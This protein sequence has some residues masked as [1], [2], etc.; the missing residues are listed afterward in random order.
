M[1]GVPLGFL[2]WAAGFLVVW[3]GLVSVGG[4]WGTVAQHWPIAA[5]MA[6]GSYFAGSTPMGGG[7]VGF[8]VLVLLFDMPASL[9]RNFG[10]AVQSVGMVSASI[11]ILLRRQPIDWH[12]LRPA[13]LGVLVGTPAGATWLAPVMPDLTVKLLFA[14]IWASFGIMHLVKLRSLVAASGRADSWPGVDRP[15]G[16]AV[17]FAGGLVA[18][19][20][21]VGCDMMIYAVLVL[22]YRADL[23]I[24]IP[25]SV[26][27]MAFASVVGI[28]SNLLL[29]RVSAAHAID[30]EVYA[31]WLAAAPV[32]LVGA[33]LGAI[34][35]QRLPR[36]P[37]LTIVSLLCI[38]QFAWTLLHEQ[39][40]GWT[41][42]ATVAG[43]LA[44][45]AAFHWMYRCGERGGSRA[46]PPA[47]QVIPASVRCDS[48]S[49]RAE[50]GA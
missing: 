25:T 23:R 28:L 8:P 50:R 38:G 14:V 20:T 36:G 17:G 45:N 46:A 26:I 34:I 48:A 31:N 6:A 5:A 10:L 41:L 33:P 27:L 11:Y 22:M 4:H 12:L 42:L 49:A 29:A 24:A 9:G 35:V 13:L 39:V 7:T 21:G 18:S 2:A 1:F 40:T 47:G 32:V 30:P 44:M 19:L 43:L 16:L 15:L 3:L 37:T